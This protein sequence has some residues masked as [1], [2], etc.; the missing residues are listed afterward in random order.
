MRFLSDALQLL[1]LRGVSGDDQLAAA[2]VRHSAIGAIGV[3]TLP[4]LHAGARLERA[5][6]VVDPGVDDLRIA[7]TRMRTDGVL[8]LEDHNVAPRGRQGARHREADNSCA[9][10]D[11]VNAVHAERSTR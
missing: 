3:Q 10:H 6:W 9:D 4:T 8:G 2:P 7:R 5:L 1:L 11:R